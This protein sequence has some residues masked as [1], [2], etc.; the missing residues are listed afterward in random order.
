MWLTQLFNQVF[1]QQGYFVVA[2]NPTGS[3]TFGQGMVN[4][5]L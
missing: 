1:A 4:A 2:I 3:T 5:K